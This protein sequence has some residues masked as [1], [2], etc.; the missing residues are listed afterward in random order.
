MCDERWSAI[1]AAQE[2][3]R[4]A[5]VEAHRAQNAAALAF[6]DAEVAL[7]ACHDAVVFEEESRARKAQDDH[8][9]RA[10]VA[11]RDEQMAETLEILGPELGLIK[12]KEWSCMSWM[13]DRRGLPP[14]W[15]FLEVDPP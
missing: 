13:H 4:E 14:P 15:W 1:R 7:S 6:F 3:R 10:M 2:Q 8:D 9:W 12:R 5:M 11:Q